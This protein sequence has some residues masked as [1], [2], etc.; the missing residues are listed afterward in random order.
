MI[1]K[2]VGIVNYGSGNILSVRRAFEH[3]GSDVTYA[4]SHDMARVDLLVLPGVGAFPHAIDSLYSSGM[5]NIVSNFADSGRPILG[6]CLGMQMLFQKS[7]ELGQ[8]NGLG[9]LDGQVEH[10][11]KCLSVRSVGNKYPVPHIGWN[12]LSI[13]PEQTTR[14]PF[15]SSLSGFFYFVHSY[16][17]INVPRENVLAVAHYGDLEIPAA[18]TNGVVTGCQFHPE[19]SGEHGLNFLKNYLASI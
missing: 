6:I 19:K 13:N 18:V 9:F 11:H 7:Y 15:S 17:A 5:R 4:D 2:K 3:I 10:I 16:M 14:Y 8:T 1:I 12:R